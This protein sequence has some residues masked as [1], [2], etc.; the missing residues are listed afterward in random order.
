MRFRQGGLLEHP[1]DY[2]D[3]QVESN[4]KGIIINAYSNQKLEVVQS[5]DEGRMPNNM[6]MILLETLPKPA[7]SYLLND[8]DHS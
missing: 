1:E 6:E 7:K 8:T 4:V 5:N 3:E 2:V